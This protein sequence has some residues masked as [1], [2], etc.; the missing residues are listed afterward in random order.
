M[1]F[2]RF[3]VSEPSRVRRLVRDLRL[4]GYI[5]GLVWTWV[6]TGGRVR[7]AYRRCERDGQTYVI[8][9]LADFDV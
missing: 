8:D 6:V 7:R 5:M 9:R 4:A 1:S 3:Y 2:D